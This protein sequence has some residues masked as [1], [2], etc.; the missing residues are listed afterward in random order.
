[1]KEPSIHFL[2]TSSFSPGID[3]GESEDQLYTLLLPYHPQMVFI[4]LWPTRQ[5]QSYDYSVSV[6]ISLHGFG[7]IKGCSEVKLIIQVLLFHLSVW[8]YN[9][10]INTENFSIFMIEVNL[11]RIGRQPNKKV[12]EIS[13][14][15]TYQQNWK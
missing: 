7:S 10:F 12:K 5:A 11:K 6:C 2:P 13:D 15:A 8:I 4:L 9:F 14:M 1:M 3:T